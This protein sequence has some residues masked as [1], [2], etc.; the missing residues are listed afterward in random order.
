MREDWLER[1]TGLTPEEKRLARL[2]H[3]AICFIVE[4]RREELTREHFQAIADVL[5]RFGEDNEWMREH[6][7]ELREK[8]PDKYI[9]VFHKKVVAS[10]RSVPSQLNKL[11]GRIEKQGIPFEWVAAKFIPKEKRVQIFALG[12]A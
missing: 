6:A 2:N 10:C 4:G 3:E 7:E 1:F 9:A 8:Y 5:K 12:G 11:R